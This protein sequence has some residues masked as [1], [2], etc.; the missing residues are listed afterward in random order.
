MTARRD[1]ENRLAIVIDGSNNCH[2]RQVSATCKGMIRQNYVTFFPS[3]AKGPH[4]KSDCFL[5]TAE[6]DR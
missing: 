1:I 2:V 4:L 6:V 5:H 3:I